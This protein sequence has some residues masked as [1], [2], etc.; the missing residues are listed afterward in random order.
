MSFLLVSLSEGMELW[1]SVAQMCPAAVPT[2]FPPAV[3]MHMVVLVK[4][5]A[6][7]Q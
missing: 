3:R 2:F 6:L 4:L 1:L 5:R 7:L